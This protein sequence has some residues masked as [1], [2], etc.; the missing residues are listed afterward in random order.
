G[1]KSGENNIYEIPPDYKTA[2]VKAIDNRPEL[3]RTRQQVVKSRMGLDAAKSTYLPSLDL[4]GRY[5]FD[6]SGLDY[7][8]D[9]ENWTAALMLRWNLFT[10]FSRPAMVSRADA[11]VREMMAADRQAAQDIK[12]D[13][14]NAYLALEE[15][16]SRYRVAESS[17]VAALE[18]YRLV[19]RQYEK[20]AASI[21][22]YLEAELDRNRARVQAVSARYDR[23]R[24]MAEV[25]RA[26]G[27]LGGKNR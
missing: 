5:Y 21:T 9:R 13:V 22:R 2:V 8:R 12:L 7:D 24:A 1:L 14:K 3:A 17:V 11:R 26:I 6:D 25:S 4:S 19:K 20:G 23:I 27:S 10:G 16:R 15:A 18:S